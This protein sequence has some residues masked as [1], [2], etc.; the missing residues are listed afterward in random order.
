LAWLA[1]VPDHL[2]VAAAALRLA[3]HL[4]RRQ[5]QHRLDGRAPGHIDQ[6]FQPDLG[7]LHQL[8]QRQQTLPVS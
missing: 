4:Q 2:T 1:A 6:L 8:H 7:A 5:F 3:R